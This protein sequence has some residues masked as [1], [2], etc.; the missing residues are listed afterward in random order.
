MFGGCGAQMTGGLVYAAAARM[1]NRGCMSV[2]VT[3]ISL[4]TT[5][6]FSFGTSRRA[7]LLV[8]R[9]EFPLLLVLHRAA[10]DLFALRIGS[11][12]GDGPGFAVR[13]VYNATRAG[14]LAPRFRR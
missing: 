7:S 2:S 10:A 11:A 9:Q 12:R 3:L 4:A 1:Q 5:N 13:R 6:A 8:T 14:T